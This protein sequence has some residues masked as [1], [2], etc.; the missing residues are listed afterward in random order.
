MYLIKILKCL[1]E[2]IYLKFKK[3]QKVKEQDLNLGLKIVNNEKQRQSL[4]IRNS[5]L[6]KG[7]TTAEIGNTSG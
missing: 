2:E 7:R 6:L 5:L 4:R 1:Q 3:C